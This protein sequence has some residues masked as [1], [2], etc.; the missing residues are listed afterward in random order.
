MDTNQRNSPDDSESL[1]SI[2]DILYILRQYWFVGTIA[3]MI[4]ACVIAAY[5]FS[6]EPQYSA[7]ASIVV[8]LDTE[9]ILDV[10]E[11]VQSGIKNPNLMVSYMNTHID[12]LKSR[13]MAKRVID[14]LDPVLEQR[15]I[16]GYI[17]PL[18]ALKPDQ[19]LPDASVLLYKYALD[20]SW[21]QESQSITIEITHS[22]R[23]LC[24]VLADQYVEQYILHKASDRTRSTSDA[25]SFLAKQV[26]ELRGELSSAEADLQ[27]YRREKNIITEERAEGIISQSMK[28]WNEAITAA[29]VRLLVAESRLKQI[30]YADGDLERLMNIPFVGGR[31]GT[32]MIHAQLQ[33]L[34]REYKVFDQIFLQNHPKMIENRASYQAVTESLW[35]AIQQAS[36]EV[37][38]ESAT[39]QAELQE[40]EGRL[41][42]SQE[43]ALNKEQDLIQYRV[44]KNRVDTMRTIYENLSARLNETTIAERMN[45]NTIRA[46]D[47]A[48]LPDSPIWPDPKKIV[49]ASGF[50]GGIVFLGIPLLISL[51]DGRVKNFFD[52]E[53]YI[54]K[55]VLGHVL[56]CH[57]KSSTTLA[58]GVLNRDEALVESFRAIYG[59]LR[60]R[61]KFGDELCSL[62]VTS[63]MSGEGKSFVASNLAAIFAKHKYRVL[64]V[65]CDLRRPVLHDDF[66]QVNERGLVQWVQDSRSTPS[67]KNANHHPELRVVSIFENLDLLRSGGLCDSPTE[68][69][70]APRFKEL[71]QTLQGNYDVI[72]YDT[73]PL[74]LFPDATLVADHANATIF[75]AR[76][77]L[78]T[79]QKV[80]YAVSVMDETHAPVIGVIFNRL[81]D[82]KNV[83]GFGKFGRNYYGYGF[84]K[85]SSQYQK[86]Y[87]QTRN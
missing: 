67:N 46:L 25:V 72:I 68:V 39:I 6:Q 4:C 28:Q 3:A 9:N 59:G 36:N 33:E 49:L 35:S 65:D 56:E 61:L 1:I 24:Q 48:T 63:S 74:G 69:L 82:V 84:E 44:L 78:V 57:G 87:K 14:S 38:V 45:L 19:K 58:R 52:I 40:L 22:D 31:E 21:G 53:S 85:D 27:G 71:I 17:G 8:E 34:T 80:R 41:H 77:N 64:L 42:D 13:A 23:L 70:G 79:R 60:L 15:F 62:V 81:R 7:K 43:Q 86:Y 30:D 66:D 83:V 51:L 50:V 18:E 75:V 10:G 26:E 2:F 73:P 12:R 54:G 76:Q 20:V 47:A 11:V 37:Q 29:R 32:Q 5:L 16:E 55:P